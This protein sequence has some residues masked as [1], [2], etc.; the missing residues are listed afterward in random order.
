MEAPAPLQSRS[1]LD[2]I[3]EAAI[4][5]MMALV[6]SADFNTEDNGTTSPGCDDYGQ[7][8]A[9]ASFLIATAMLEQRETVRSLYQKALKEI[10]QEEAA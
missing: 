7:H 5:A 10:E 9:K 1:D 6:S 2:F 4:S 3:D 8:V